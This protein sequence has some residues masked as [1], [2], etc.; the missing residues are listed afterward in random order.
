MTKTYILKTVSK[1]WHALEVACNR[2]GSAGPGSKLTEAE[3][4]AVT[5]EREHRAMGRRFTN[6]QARYSVSCV[7]AARAIVIHHVYSGYRDN[8]KNDTP[9]SWTDA[10]SIRQD[11]ALAYAIREHLT[12]VELASLK[13]AA[14]IDYAGDIALP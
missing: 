1:A 7:C 8:Q 3:R 11:C 6:G 13:E 4:I 5:Q 2:G 14:G 10:T 9:L 12:T